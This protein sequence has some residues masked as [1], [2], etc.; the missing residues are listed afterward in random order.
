MKYGLMSEDFILVL[1]R[2]S[3]AHLFPSLQ[4]SD[5][6][7]CQTAHDVRYKKNASFRKNAV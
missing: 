7:K 4:Q 6:R 3:R 2:D 1:M 5:S